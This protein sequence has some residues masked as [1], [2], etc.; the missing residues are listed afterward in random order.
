MTVGQRRIERNANR[1]WERQRDDDEP[2]RS[3]APGQSE[4]FLT[5]MV[6]NMPAVVFAK[7]YRRPAASFC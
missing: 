6:E 2:Q 1:R 7:D 4:A 3:S 5:S